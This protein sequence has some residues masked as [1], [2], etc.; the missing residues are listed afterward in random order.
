MNALSFFL[1]V[2]RPLGFLYGGLMLLRRRLYATGALPTTRVPVPV[3]CVGNLSMGGS[4]KTPI[5][6]YLAN[7][8]Q[9]AGYHPVIISRGY[10][11]KTG[12]RV[13]V[14][15]DHDQVRMSASDAGDE[16]C[17]LAGKLPGIPV[18][19]GRKRK[20][21]ALFA[22]EN[23]RCD[24]LL[25]DD[26]FQHLALHRDM[27]IVLFNTRSLSKT[28]RVLPAGYLREPFPA[29]RNAKAILFTNYTDGSAEETE[30]YA[31]DHFPA[32][33][34]DCIY[35]AGYGPECLIDQEGKRFPISEISASVRCGAF[36]GIAA[37]Q[38]FFTSLNSL[39]INL[40][41]TQSFPDHHAYTKR[42]LDLL[43]ETA[44]SHEVQLLLTTEKDLV[45]ISGNFPDIPL[46]ALVMKA[47]APPEFD[48]FILNRLSNLPR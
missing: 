28:T 45:K 32:E 44:A 2:M 27:D 22:V 20:Y 36:C 46:R 15:S 21:P 5:V 8:L 16:P 34:S 43:S 25:L 39:G 42:E 4:G 47:T 6:L 11:G 7:L 14:V 13:N 26:G 9:S 19:T 18:L 23:F 37:P 1:F 35:T 24:I 29:L 33:L 41:F 40:V 48:R 10:K 30:Q 12:E 3:I 17:L 31:A 38:R